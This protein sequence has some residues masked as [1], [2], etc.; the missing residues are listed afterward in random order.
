MFYQKL[1]RIKLKKPK[2]IGQAFRTK[3][4]CLPDEGCLFF[5]FNDVRWWL[6]A[7]AAFRFPNHCF[8]QSAEG[9]S[10]DG[11][12]MNRCRFAF[13]AAFADALNEG[14]FS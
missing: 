3:S 8:S 9:Q 11:V 10:G 5:H 1:L 14:N 4:E 7:V 2:Q 6:F 13:V 12:A